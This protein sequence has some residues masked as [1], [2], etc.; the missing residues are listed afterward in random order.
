MQCNITVCIYIMYLTVHNTPY[1]K[2]INT[3]KNES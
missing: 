2:Y 3:D 1:Q